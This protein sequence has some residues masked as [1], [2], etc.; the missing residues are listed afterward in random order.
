MNEL[1]YYHY[2]AMVSGLLILLFD[3]WWLIRRKPHVEVLESR[4]IRDYES[5]GY[6]LKFEGRIVNSGEGAAMLKKAE[7]FLYL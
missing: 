4:L 7:A 5:T 3:T 2:F 1:T 6:G